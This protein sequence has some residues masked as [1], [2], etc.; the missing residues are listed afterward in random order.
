MTELNKNIK[1]LR[2]P[3]V[4]DVIPVGKSTWW[5]WVANGKAPKGLKLSERCTVWRLSDIQ[6]FIDNLEEI[7][8]E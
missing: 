2:I 1:L 6:E 4:L 8:H 3:E 7:G 5:E